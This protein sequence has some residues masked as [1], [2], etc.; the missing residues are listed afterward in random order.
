M[1]QRWGVIFDMD[2]VLV[3]SYVAHFQ[4]WKETAE[5][6]GQKL[7]EEEFAGTFG[8]TSPSIIQQL[9]GP[10]AL[11][12][13]QM[14]EFD[15]IKEQRYREIVQRDLPVMPGVK[16]LI[17]ALKQAGVELAV[18]SSGPP[19][20]VALALEALGVRALFSAV[21]TGRDV[22]HGKPDP[23]VFLLAAERMSIPPRWCVVIE[24]APVGVEAARRA[25]MK[26][27]GLQSPPPRDRDLSHA[28]LVV[29]SHRELSPKRLRELLDLVEEGRHADGR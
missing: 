6:F 17:M 10:A 11:T 3:D 5:L 27:V 25:G 24:D 8:Q 14:V 18:G 13:E 7:T 16:D 4:S 28:N 20:N 2:G 29:H 1:S 12:Q 9:W 26:S 15:R 23:Q 22:Q 19:E 21:V